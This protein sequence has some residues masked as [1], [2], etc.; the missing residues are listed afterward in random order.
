VHQMLGHQVVH[1]QET[2]AKGNGQQYESGRN[3]TEFEVFE[4]VQRWQVLHQAAEFVPF[5]RVV[6][7]QS[8]DGVNAR[9]AQ[10]AKSD[11]GTDNVQNGAR[12]EIGQRRFLAD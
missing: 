12:F 2:R 3:Q 9:Q 7:D 11:Y 8:E 10:Y 1:E 5:E 4:F 6:Y